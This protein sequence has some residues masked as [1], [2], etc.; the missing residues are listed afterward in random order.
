MSYNKFS[1]KAIRSKSNQNEAERMLTE[2]EVNRAYEQLL[3]R[4]GG[5]Q[6]TL[7]M[8]ANKLREEAG[9]LGYRG[10]QTEQP[11]QPQEQPKDA[12]V[13]YGLDLFGG[14]N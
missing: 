1:D 5:E 13:S 6:A 8:L 4:Y 7:A 12:P 10:S 9:R 3:N 11:K 2:F 14:N